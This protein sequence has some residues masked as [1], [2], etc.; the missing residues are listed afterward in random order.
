MA[1]FDKRGRYW[2]AQ[3]RRRGYPPQTQSFDTKGEAEIWARSVE[4]AMDRGLWTDNREASRTTL[5]EALERY[6]RE[7][8]PHKAPTSIRVELSRIERLKAHSLA[9]RFLT[10]V[11]GVDLA[12]YRDERLTQGKATNTVRIELA[13]L[14]HL[15]STCR[16][17]WGM[18]GL[19][20]PA[21]N[22]R[23]PSVSAARDRRLRPGE[24]ERIRAALAE[25][26]NGYAAAAFELAIETALR[27]GML[28]HLR[29]TWVDLQARVIPI[30]PTFRKRKNKGVP[31]VLPL[32][33]RA[34]EILRSLPRSSD[35]RV[36]ATTQNAV[37][38]V[39]RKALKRLGIEDLH[40]HDLRHEAASRLAEHGAGF[41]VMDLAAFTGHADPKMVRRYVNL[42]AAA[43]ARRMAPP[44]PIAGATTAPG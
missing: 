21:S 35:G 12:K 27:Q 28:F 7:V 16:K 23:K 8:T 30:P 9:S 36:L 6:A 19:V 39:W 18:E 40:F 10:N 38:M 31:D 11:R 5:R 25:S 32:S 33:P 15:Y 4:S 3:V 29:W 20:N 2:R 41:S 24:F 26:G 43:L 1:S 14:G 22:L 37:V 34:I 13:L 44:V 42:D 17:D